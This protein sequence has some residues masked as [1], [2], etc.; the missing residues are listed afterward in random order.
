M[1]FSVIGAARI[2]AE[3]DASPR[4]GAETA[5]FA[6]LVL[7]APHAVSVDTLTEG[8]WGDAA[9]RQ[10]R[11]NLAAYV[12]RVRRALERAG[13]DRTL[14]EFRAQHYALRIPPEKVDWNRFRTLQRTAIALSTQGDHAGAYGAATEALDA[15]QDD[16]VPD[17]SGP[18]VEGVRVTMRSAHQSTLAQWARAALECGW[19]A[20]ALDRLSSAVTQYPCNEELVEALMRALLATGR[21][22]DALTAYAQLRQRLADELGT[23][24]PATLRGLHRRILRGEEGPAHP[25]DSPPGRRPI[26]DNLPR[27]IGDFS[28]R[29]EETAKVVRDARSESRQDATA[30]HV[31]SGISGTGKST[32]AVHAAHQLKDGYGYRLYLDLCGGDARLHPISAEE[33]LAELLGLLGVDVS[34][35]HTPRTVGHWSALWRDL[36]REVSLL[37]VLDNAASAEQ[38]LPLLP[39][40]PDC[41]VIV[42]S[43][44]RMSDLDGAT[45]TALETLPPERA[46]EMLTAVSGGRDDPEFRDCAPGIVD[47]C[48]GL[49]LALRLAGG[50]L[51]GP[52]AWAPHDYLDHLRSQPAYEGLR[53]GRRSVR[54]TFGLTLEALPRRASRALF[55]L[56]LFP[57]PTMDRWAAHALIGTDDRFSDEV[58]HELTDS[59]LLTETAPESFSQHSMVGNFVRGRLDEELT[60]QVRQ[61]AIR[62]MLEAALDRCSRAVRRLSL[63]P[64]DDAAADPLQHGEPKGKSLEWLRRQPLIGLVD[65]AAQHG[66]AYHAA[67]L[68]HL[69]AD[70][71]DLYGPW[72]RAVE[73]HWTA[74]RLAREGELHAYG[75]SH[76]SR[77]LLRTGALERA[78]GT[79]EEARAAWERLG[80]RRR[81]ARALDLSG[82]AAAHSGNL[83]DAEQRHRAAVDGYRA[84]GDRR[85]EAVAHRH[86]ADALYQ[87]GKLNA[88]AQVYSV[89][90]ATAEEVFPEAAAIVRSNYAGVLHDMG[91]HREA[92]AVVEE[93]L[94]YLVRTGDHRRAGAVLG[95]SGRIAA[96]RGDHSRALIVLTEAL[97]LQ[98][99]ANDRW[100]QSGTWCTIGTQHLALGRVEE[101]L[102]AFDEC[103][104]I[105]AFST[106]STRVNVLMGRAEAALHAGRP[107][108]ASGHLLRA[109]GI[110]KQGGLIR[111]Q[112]AAAARLGVVES[113]RNHDRAARSRLSEAQ[114]LYAELN[115]PE[116]SAVSALLE[117]TDLSSQEAPGQ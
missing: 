45:H 95:N 11:Q 114:R 52:T 67:R 117:A 66:F 30:V 13:L 55:L 27:D 23:D 102:A 106:S 97:R 21:S 101:A 36:T 15:W 78:L 38:I 34:P 84:A 91:Y 81:A 40:G 108:E 60:P 43:Q 93:V 47:I 89:A 85:G 16:P 87:Q 56:G 5:V 113:E 29:R 82:V 77:A 28:A 42:T 75:L 14:L 99:A 71:L 25:V 110:A 72:D 70:Y 12:T 59:S 54:A 46:M 24:P 41:L 76:L 115:A 100:A 94:A 64:E 116:E 74:L 92:R 19:E 83:R 104:R 44:R 103:D 26:R 22:A 73:L 50:R 32:L 107:A 33:A 8:L 51:S 9:P 69:L 96:R 7:A 88:A 105:E 2:R 48:D 20:D 62:R 31:I 79:A 4:P 3:R 39:A 63:H 68:A 6:R 1:E 35:E 111:D 49:P 86:V 53:L 58:L 18:W 37:V 65:Y 98:K 10:S 90:L 112:A 109:R 57:A 17:G 61:T 80:D